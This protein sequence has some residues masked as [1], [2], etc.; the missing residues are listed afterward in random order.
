MECDILIPAAMESVINLN[1]ADR[2]NTKLIIEAANGPITAGGDEILRK[3]G[4][5][6]IP[7]MYANAVVS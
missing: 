2:I 5:V 1:N 7:D 6:I 3:K 4:V